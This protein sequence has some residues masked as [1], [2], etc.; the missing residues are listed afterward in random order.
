MLFPIFFYNFVWKE[1]HFAMEKHEITVDRTTLL[2]NLKKYFGFDGFKGQQEAVIVNLLQ[3]KDTFV[4]MPT[5]GG[6]SLCYQLPALMMEGTAI[7][8]SPL[9]ALMKNQVDAVRQVSEDDGIAHYI[10]SSLSRPQ[11]HQVDADLKSGRTKL[12]YMA[13][14]WLT[15]EETKELL[16]G[17]KVSFYA[18]DEAHCISEWGLDFRP[19]YRRIRPMINEVGRAP[20]IALTAT[21][22]KKV[23]RDIKKNLSIMRAEEFVSSFNR[24]NLYYEVRPKTKNVDKDI[25]RFIMQ[26][27]GK[28]GIIYCLSRKKVEQLADILRANDIKASAYHAGM[29]TEERN[30]TQDDFIMERVDVI[31]ATIAFGMGIDKPDVRYVIH[32]DIPKSLEGYYQETGRAGR[33]GGEGICLAFYSPADL[34]KLRKFMKDKKVNE[35]EIGNQL[36]A[37]TKAY[38]ETNVCRRRMLLHYFGENYSQNNCHCCDNCSRPHESINGSRDLVMVLDVIMAVKEKFRAG[39]IINI[40]TGVETEEVTSHCHEQLKWFGQGDEHERE[41]WEALIRQAML[42]GY[43]EKE[44]ENYGV[45]HVTPEGRDFVKAPT[46]FFFLENNQ[47]ENYEPEPESGA[48]VLDE[49]L[50]KMLKTLRRDIARKL[51]I[52]P[53]VIFMDA[54]LEAMATVY[55]ETRDELINIPGVGQGK[56]ER[57]GREFCEL[58]KKYCEEN[59][60]DRPLDLRIRTVASSSKQKIVIISKIDLKQPLDLIAKSLGIEFEELLD[61]LESIVYSGTKIDISYY[62]DDVMDED[63]MLDIW[64]YF[65]D[66]SKTD[67]IS[68]AMKELGPDYEERDIRL[69]R[70]KFLSECGN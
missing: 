1:H 52:P 67:R 36:L 23:R 47:F 19:E 65:H 28:S 35:Q 58:I 62:I 14:E 12:L 32:Y 49:T 50:V 25:I 40:V 26:N 57:Y 46:M 8:L 61:E 63:C 45:L 69:V 68:V 16:R 6:K 10:N 53:Y 51:G 3:R 2:E 41:Y 55:P 21:A 9:I 7:V 56:A 60:I 37:E 13:P 64:D 70:I 54:S 24:P 27:K 59:E 43:I 29:D 44:V 48:G 66:E 5:G 15:K 17:V 30:R 18:I 31:V 4:L 22:T 42:D 11:I 34:D 38:C 33:D 20:I 39:H